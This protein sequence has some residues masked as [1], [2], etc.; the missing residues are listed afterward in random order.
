MYVELVDFWMQKL[1][2]KSDFFFLLYNGYIFMGI[3]EGKEEFDF[4]MLQ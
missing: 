3:F 4:L 1:N 2:I